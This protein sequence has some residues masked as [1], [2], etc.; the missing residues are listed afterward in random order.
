MFSRSERFVEKVNPTPGPGHYDVKLQDDD[1]Y[2][3]FG[4][5][6]KTKRFNADK[7]EQH[8]GANNSPYNRV[9]LSVSLPSLGMTHSNGSNSSCPYVV[10]N[11]PDS[12]I[13]R[14]S[15]TTGGSTTPES[16]SSAAAGG[17]GAGAGGVAPASRSTESLGATM[18]AEERLKKEL[19]EM[20]ERLEKAR[21]I[22]QKELDSML[23]KQKKIEALYQKTLKEKTT[24]QAQLVTKDSELADL[25]AKH[26]NL[27]SRL[28]KAEKAANAVTDKAQKTTHLQKRVDELDRANGRLKQAL[29]EQQQQADKLSQQLEAERRRWH[30]TSQ[31]HAAQVAQLETKITQFG[32][33]ETE[34]GQ[35][36][37]ELQETLATHR[38]K[39]AALER[40]L[41][42]NETEARRQR[43]Q[44]IQD[45]Q[46]HCERLEQQHKT[47]LEALE[48]E[49]RTAVDTLE[50]EHAASLASHAAD[51][52]QQR[53]ANHRLRQELTEATAREQELHTTRERLQ[54][55]LDEVRRN[56]QQQVERS[57]QEQQQYTKDRHDFESSAGKLMNELAVNRDALVKAQNERSALEQELQERDEAI[58]ELETHVAVLQMR[59]QELV[60]AAEY[61]N[62]R[63]TSLQAD[64]EALQKQANEREQAQ[65]NELESLRLSNAE[66]TRALEQ[67]KEDRL[68]EEAEWQVKLEQAQQDIVP[69]RTSL[70]AARAEVDS[71]QT[72]LAGQSTEFMAL[73]GA[74]QEIHRVATKADEVDADKAWKEQVAEV[75]DILRQLLS[76]RRIFEQTLLEIHGKH[77]VL[78]AT[79]DQLQQ[80]LDAKQELLELTQKEHEEEQRKRQSIFG[81]E[82]AQLL[83]K[84]ELLE[85]E[86]R[87]LRAQVDFLE[88][89][90]IGKV[91]IVKALQDEYDYQE[92]IIR[93]LSQADDATGEISRLEEELR[94]LT[95]HTREMDEWVKAVKADAEKY[96]EAYLKADVAREQTLLDMG[97]LHEQIAELESSK[98]TLEMHVQSD[99]SVLLRK[100]QLS[101]EEMSRLAKISNEAN[102]QQNLKQ[103]IKQVA[104]LKEE[105]IDL[106]KK[107]ISVA[108]HRDQLRLKCLR[109]EREL[110]AYKDAS[111]GVP[112]ATIAQMVKRRQQKLEEHQ[113]QKQGQDKHSRCVSPSASS[114]ISSLNIPS[115]TTITPCQLQ[116]QQRPRS[117]SNSTVR[118]WSSERRARSDS[119]S[120]GHTVIITAPDAPP[121]PSTLPPLPTGQLTTSAA[122]ATTP[123]T[124]TT[125]TTMTTTTTTTTTSVPA[126][127]AAA[128]TATVTTK[129][130]SQ[131]APK[132]IP[133]ASSPALTKGRSLSRDARKPMS[134]SLSS[135]AISPPSPA[136]P[137]PKAA[138]LSATTTISGPPKAVVRSR[139]ARSYLT[140]GK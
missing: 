36:V 128:T 77:E 81:Q 93:D 68:K 133:R 84:M 110:E 18:R 27:K 66:L 60:S 80:M 58:G 38:D 56:Y 114:I 100:H 112:P 41:E 50:R 10:P 32:L 123:I 8:G 69:V 103:K 109:L 37:R 45:H 96:R 136:A 40:T 116:F 5:L 16:I 78:A 138:A 120:S 85:E 82:Y 76:E 117:A 30:E 98:Q 86:I 19:T 42:E 106:K 71:L 113:S 44:L 17:A 6:A 65:A 11:T 129:A 1:P 137:C 125:T 122:E 59:E 127:T 97:R 48:Q 46:E 52:D 39:I 70:D 94:A 88:A 14:D 24:L 57:E 3:R 53:Q 49:H 132:P 43:D 131:T 74:I 25:D 64:F 115:S 111:A 15:P 12:L 2:K 34:L 126:A 121:L 51:M 95:N 118:S 7:V 87:K 47:A 29:Q 4:F 102:Q 62:E 35:M 75:I 92:R 63:Y 79:Y 107:Q 104:Q 28:D 99:I 139:A 83:K 135:P 23:E 21:A 33:S 61:D 13:S 108:N 119:V 105:N 72:H 31:D 124:A 90:N 89:E 54:E 140:G 91:A 55:E 20:A 9:S 73:K 130:A 67:Q 22:H 134:T 101:P 26:S